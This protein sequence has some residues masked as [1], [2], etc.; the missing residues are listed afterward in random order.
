MCSVSRATLRR[1]LRLPAADVPPVPALA[2]AVGVFPLHVV[3]ELD[4]RARRGDLAGARVGR[5]RD[6]ELHG[7]EGAH[8]SG[9]DG[10]RC[11]RR[12]V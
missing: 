6:V 5:A 10:G 1:R 4:S 11:L 9:V 3:D 12:V 7:V 8:A 2:P